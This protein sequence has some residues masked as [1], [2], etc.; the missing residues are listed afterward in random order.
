VW[1]SRRCRATLAAI[2]S[3]LSLSLLVA[4][5]GTSAGGS[6]DGSNGTPVGDA[7]GLPDRGPA[8][9]RVAFGR[10]PASIDPRHLADDEGE[11]VVRA[12]FDGLVDVAPDGSVVGAAATSW[13]V[14]DEGLT[15]RFLLRDDRFHDG[16]PVTA[17]D[18]AVALL[19][20]LD[21]D[22]APLFRQDLLAGLV[23][24]G[25]G[26]PEEVFIAGGIEVLG[27]RELVLRLTRPDPSLLYRL[28]DP[29]LVPLPA[30]ARTDP[31]AFALEPIG[32]GPFRM[33]GPREPGA[34]IRLTANAAHPRPPRIDGLVLQIYASDIDREQ[35]WEDL[36]AGRLQ[37]TA[38]P[39]G[40]R[41]EARD[42][43]GVALDGRR[44]RGLYEE[45]GATL[46]AYAFV[47][48][49]APFDDPVLRRALSAA[50]DRDGMALQLAAAGVE[51][52]DA[53]LAPALGGTP[54]DCAHCRYDPALA[55]QLVADWRAS[56]PEADGDPQVTLTYPR[57]DGHVAI[58][59]R[60]AADVERVLGFD[61]RLQSRDLGALVRAVTAGEVPLFRYGLRASLGGD[62]AALSL[63]D[64][65]FRPGADGNWVRWSDPTTI[66]LL[67][68]LHGSADPVLARAVEA[69]VLDTAA[70]IPLLWSRPDV[71]VHPDVVG[72]HLDVT[73]RWWP[74]LIRLR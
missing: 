42:R 2:A 23:G 36:L 19:G 21:P 73:G 53:I 18:H 29:V 9:I 59:E 57:G 72:F 51:P 49:V 32:N 38:I 6:A 70:V 60:I 55:E 43:F 56:R 16:T 54:T 52:A 74:E 67:D 10:D 62:A 39:P 26:E 69:A 7:A 35:R 44:G 22:R 8:T 63:L 17:A 14:E 24:A 65:A 64:P 68:A 11:Q 12:L 28:A 20:A 46:Y 34:F 25:A 4:G 33:L 41:E 48:D 30:R 1:S 61:V 45:P 58:A 40:R 27:P 71:V 50:V 3:S 31:E 15:Y 13:T 66:A 37:I 5:C 47:L